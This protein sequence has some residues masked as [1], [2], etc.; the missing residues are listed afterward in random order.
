M[1]ENE[2]GM[3]FVVE[4]VAGAACSGACGVAALNHEVFYYA[5][6]DYAVVEAFL[7]EFDKVFNGF[8][9]VIAEK[10]DQYFTVIGF[11]GCGSCVNSHAVKCTHTRLGRVGWNG[12]QLNLAPKGNRIMKLSRKR[13]RELRKLRGEAEGLIQQ[14]RAVFG[15]AS[16]VLRSAGQEAVELSNEHLVPRIDESVRFARP[17]LLRG[18][19]A[20]KRFFYNLRLL[21]SP[22]VTRALTATL[23]KLEGAGEPEA[24]DAARLVRQFGEKTGYLARRRR[25]SKGWVGVVLG[26]V[27]ALGVV[28]A[29]WQAFSADDELWIASDAEEGAED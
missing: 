13:S 4:G 8:W 28:F 15:R 26:A 25:S 27:A 14:Q 16:E 21:T 10:V 5:V 24:Q 17:Y 7:C 22:F 23:E 20:G 9:G 12:T 2:F 29:L 11:D 3:N 1:V 19:D 6:K 18:L